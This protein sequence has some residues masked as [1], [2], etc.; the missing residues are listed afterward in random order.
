MK[1][2]VNLYIKY[3][4]ILVLAFLSY[5]VLK[6]YLSVIILSLIL[7]YMC[8]PIKRLLQK[9]IKNENLVAVLITGSVFLIILIPLLLLANALLQQ[10]AD[11]YT[12][13]NLDD[14]KQLFSEKLNIELSE[15]TQQYINNVT[16]TATSYILTK[17]SSFIFSIPNL[18]VSFFIM[19]CMLFFALRDGEKVLEKARQLLPLEDQYKK[20]F[21]KKLSSSIQSLFYGTMALAA[22]E[23]VVAIAGFYF[24]GIEAPV[25]W[26]FVIGLTAILPGI[27]ATIVWMPMAIIAFLNGD[28]TNAILIILFGF[29]ILST[30]IDTIVRAKILGMRAE[31]HPLIIIVGV[32]GGLAAFGFIGMLI[33]PLILSLFELILEIYT[34]IRHEAQN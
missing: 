10:A 34:E 17:V 18:I 4:F 12:T 33:G 21:E 26:G 15:K 19:L 3:A 8:F 28:T 31:I 30:F 14:I 20:R 7:A 2:E 11:V 29:L 27:G 23:S 6:P 9:K 24:L 22:L 32:L 16:K 5:L 1:S 25:L 13:T